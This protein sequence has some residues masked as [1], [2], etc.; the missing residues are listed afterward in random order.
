MFNLS[1]LKLKDTTELHLAHPVTGEKLYADAAKKKPVIVFLYGSSSVQ[2][3]TYML[4][5]QNRHLKSSKQVTKAE[6][7]REEG[8]ELLV[9]CSISISNLE[10]RKG[11]A[12]D[13]SDAFREIYSDAGYG[14]LKAQVDESISDAAGFLEV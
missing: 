13:N 5:M 2:Y 6:L 3:Q 14:W 7:L 11:V 8:I 12:V 4:A 10:L 9:A 1:S